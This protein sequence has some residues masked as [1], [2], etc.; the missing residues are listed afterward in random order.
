[1]LK[2]LGAKIHRARNDKGLSLDAAARSAGIS[3]AYLHKL[4]H[5]VVNSP[6]PRVLAR[7]AVALEVPYFDLMGAAG[8]LDEEEL[9]KARARAPMEHPLAKASLSPAEWRKVGRFIQEL[10][11]SR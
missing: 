5:G 7:V 9:A 2:D 4:E 11:E 1:M 3:N 6:S 8:Y 10:V